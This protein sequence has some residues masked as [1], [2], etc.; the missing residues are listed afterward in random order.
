MKGFLFWEVLTPS[1]MYA[2]EIASSIGRV[3]KN[4]WGLSWG[5][6]ETNCRR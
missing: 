5:E 4:D 3:Y 2:R 6:S 1:S